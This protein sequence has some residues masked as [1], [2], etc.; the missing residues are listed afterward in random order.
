MRAGR[1]GYIIHFVSRMRGE[2]SGSCHGAEPASKSNT[3]PPRALLRPG[4]QRARIALWLGRS[5]AKQKQ[6]GRLSSQSLSFR[7]ILVCEIASHLNYSGVCVC[8]CVGTF[9]SLILRNSSIM[10]KDF[11]SKSSSDMVGLVRAESS[12]TGNCGSTI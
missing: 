11:L 5:G 7:E 2:R 3:R 6:F 8:V 12:L 9:M 4:S 10:L 1:Y